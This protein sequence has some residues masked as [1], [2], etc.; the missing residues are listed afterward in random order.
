LSGEKV[1]IQMLG[2]FSIR[3]GGQEISDSDNRSRK[4]WLL[5]AYIIYCRSRNISQEE[6]INLL[7]GDEVGSSN[8]GNALKTMFHRVRTTLDQLGGNAGHVLIIRKNGTYAWNPNTDCTL[9]T[10]DFEA[11]CKEGSAAAD[12]SGRLESFLRALALYQG[13]FLP[14]LTS[15]PWI[16]PLNAY[17][18]NLYV[19]T[20]R[21][22]VA[23]LETQG[24]MDE[25]A[26]LCRKAA[27]IEPYDEALYRHLM[28]ELLDLG[29]Q[30]EA[31][32]VYQ[33]MSDLMFQNFGVMPSDEA[34]ALYREAVRTVNEREVSLGF[35][36][37]QLREPGNSVGALFC[38]YDFFKVIYHAEAR[39]VAR[40]GDAV[41]IGLLSVSGEGGELPRRSLDICMSN[42]Q[43]LICSC[44]RRG[45]V[46]ARCSLTQ[47]II[48]L[49]QA[50][51]ENSCMV[52]ERIIKAFVRQHPHSPAA[53][54]FSVQP[55]EPNV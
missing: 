5:L 13:D 21:D 12:E 43:E 52:M 54:R 24:R 8:P 49:P 4:V 32:D 48:L 29:R 34:K 27:E 9:D 45:D 28:R 2:Q 18:H 31:I 19:Q 41:H 10:D 55:L 38:D 35:V 15:E 33:N 36:R 51:Y 11:Q 16:V 40:S 25:A 14:K 17:F 46:A 26:V 47:F 30:R 7:W 50:N 3:M 20:A 42:L 23:I 37:E 39:A 44:L 6:L 22:T 53:L 1:Q